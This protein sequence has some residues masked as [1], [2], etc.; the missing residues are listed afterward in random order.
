MLLLKYKIMKKIFTLLTLS[1]LSFSVASAQI[2]SNL[3][4]GSKGEQVKELQKFLKTEE[5][6]TFGS[7]TKA[8]LIS[9]QKLNRISGTGNTGP[10]T[11]NSINKILPTLTSNQNVQSVVQ[12]SNT[13]SLN[14]ETVFTSSGNQVIDLSKYY[15]FGENGLYSYVNKITNQVIKTKAL[16][17]KEYNEQST[18]N[19][20]LVANQ[21]PV[22]TKTETSQQVQQSNTEYLEK[23]STLDKCLA[24]IN[25]IKLDSQL[26]KLDKG[27]LGGLTQSGANAI[28]NEID[29]Q[30]AKDVLLLATSDQCVSV[31]GYIPQY[32]LTQPKTISCSI[33]Y[34]GFGANYTAICQ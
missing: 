16:E 18:Q 21:Y 30:A 27:R 11:R 26:K 2:T 20:Q 28:D 13:E 10:S 19:I 7:K 29:R 25:K 14:Y 5:T 1:L 32:L 33:N 3:S 9:Y 12:T 15:R 24:D 34:A 31:I 17:D 4:V 23:K 22:Q 8:A 6:G